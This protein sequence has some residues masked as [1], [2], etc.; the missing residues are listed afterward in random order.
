MTCPCY[1]CSYASTATQVRSS[2]VF[3]FVIR[4]TNEGLG[5]QN[6]DQM[7]SLPT[8]AA[9][10]R[11]RAPPD[12][13]R[14]GNGPIWAMRAHDTAPGKRERSAHLSAVNS[15]PSPGLALSWTAAARPRRN[16]SGAHGTAAMRSTRPAR[17]RTPRRPRRPPPRAA[18]SGSR[19][20]TTTTRTWSCDRS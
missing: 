18:R 8:C 3:A 11:S 15:P 6:A 19:A 16:Q 17:R 2:A 12:A 13:R 20:P 4:T 5:C 10:S 14:Y 1:A 9:C 7:R